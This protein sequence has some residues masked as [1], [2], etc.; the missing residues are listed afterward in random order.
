MLTGFGSRHSTVMEEVKT[1]IILICFKKKEPKNFSGNKTLFI[2]KQFLRKYTAIESFSCLDCWERPGCSLVQASKTNGNGRT[3]R[4]VLAPSLTPPQY[5]CQ[6]Q[7]AL[8]MVLLILASSEVCL[9]SKN[10]G[11]KGFLLEL[12]ASTQPDLLAGSGHTGSSCLRT[13]PVRSV[14]EGSGSQQ[15]SLKW[16]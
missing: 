2:L 14:T 12:F 5:N 6:Q 11:F 7:F 1:P 15:A 13:V 4:E 9:S 16:K 3:A 8:Q 10:L